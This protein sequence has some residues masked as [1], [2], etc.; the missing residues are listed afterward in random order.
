MRAAR[1][2]VN[3]RKVLLLTERINAIYRIFNILLHLFWLRLAMT[4]N[5]I[6]T[7]KEKGIGFNMN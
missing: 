2:I 7:L 3:G 5:D 6:S 1:K 4:R